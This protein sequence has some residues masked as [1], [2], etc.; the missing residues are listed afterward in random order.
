MICHLKKRLHTFC[1]INDP[2]L[3]ACIFSVLVTHFSAQILTIF[4]R[5]N[6]EYNAIQV[7]FYFCRE[8]HDYILIMIMRAIL[9]LFTVLE[10]LLPISTNIFLKIRFACS[11]IFERVDF[12]GVISVQAENKI[13]WLNVK[14]WEH[15]Q[16]NTDTEF[17][18]RQKRQEH[19]SLRWLIFPVSR[20]YRRQSLWCQDGQPG[21]SW[22]Y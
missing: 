16:A 10:L 5:W 19:Q 6:I 4:N 3:H 8:Y 21:R 2:C 20:R 7:I 1:W 9:T 11:L 15:F 18:S 12:V 14:H 22:N 13:F 17:I